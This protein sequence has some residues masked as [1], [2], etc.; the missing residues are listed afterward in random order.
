[1]VYRWEGVGWGVEELART[2]I[3]RENGIRIYEVF[4]FVMLYILL[5]YLGK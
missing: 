1:V 3:E 2:G 4:I 5:S